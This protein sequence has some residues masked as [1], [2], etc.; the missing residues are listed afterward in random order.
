VLLSKH[1]W[2]TRLVI[3]IHKT[4]LLHQ[5]DEYI[6]FTPS[7]PHILQENGAHVQ[8]RQA[9][10]SQ[11]CQFTG[12]WRTTSSTVG[13]SA[14]RSQAAERTTTHLCK[15]DRKRPAIVWMLLCRTRAVLG[16]VIPWGFVP[17]SGMKAQ[18]LVLQAIS[19]NRCISLKKMQNRR[20]TDTPF[21]DVNRT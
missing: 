3:C 1:L 18:R 19:R 21:M 15:Q 6:G 14:Q 17:M 8:N 13:S 12:K 20:W 4:S 5:P 16:R 2:K 7:S 9:C 11:W 10:A